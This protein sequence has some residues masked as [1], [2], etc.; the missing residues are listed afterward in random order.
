MEITQM[1]LVFQFMQSFRRRRFDKMGP[2]WDL[3]DP[4]QDI[5]NDSYIYWRATHATVNN[6][7]QLCNIVRTIILELRIWLP[8]S[9]IHISYVGGSKSSDTNYIPENRFIMNGE[10]MVHLLM[11]YAHDR[12]TVSPWLSDDVITW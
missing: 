4:A 12:I 5:P 7:Q 3:C 10:M 2:V 1:Y 9:I 6:S 8:C 11:A